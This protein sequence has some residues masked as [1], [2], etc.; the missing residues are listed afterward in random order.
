MK[1]EAE[2]WENKGCQKPEA[3]ASD[4]C[5]FYLFFIFLVLLG[6]FWG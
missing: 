5:F 1:R 3:M 4:Y 2:A 6:L